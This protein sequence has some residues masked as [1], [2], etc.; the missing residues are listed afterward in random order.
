VSFIQ[1]EIYQDNDP[2][3]PVRPQVARWRLPSEPWAF[4]IDRK[5]RIT[6]RVEGIFSA[7]E[8]ARAVDAV[9]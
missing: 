2:G 9:K 7:G 6:W 3:K 8:L 1:Q 4:V 5:G